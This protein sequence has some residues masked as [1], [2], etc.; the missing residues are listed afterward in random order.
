LEERAISL[1]WEAGGDLNIIFDNCSGQNKNNTM[2]KLA[3]LLKAMGYVKKVNF[4]FP[5]CWSY[6]K[7]I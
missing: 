7:C 5:Y 3:A 6:Q 1:V 4:D 2:L